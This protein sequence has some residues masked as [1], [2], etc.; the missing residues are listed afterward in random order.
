MLALMFDMLRGGE[1][2]YFQAT[3]SHYA[4]QSVCNNT[5]EFMSRK[6]LFDPLQPSY[7]HRHMPTTTWVRYGRFGPEVALIL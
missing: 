2:I 7:Q 1:E 3:L 4:L 6:L 5:T